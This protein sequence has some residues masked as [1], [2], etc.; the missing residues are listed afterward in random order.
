MFLMILSKLE[1]MLHILFDR[2]LDPIF[3]D[4]GSIFGGPNFDFCNTLH[5]FSRFFNISIMSPRYSQDPPKSLPRPLLGGVLGANFALLAR[6]WAL[7]GALGRS[8][9]A[10]GTLLG[11]PWTLLGALGGSWPLLR[12]SWDALERSW[13]PRGTLLARFRDLPGSILGSPQLLQEV[14]EQPKRRKFR[15]SAASCPGT[16]RD[17]SENQIQQRW[18]ASSLLYRS[19]RS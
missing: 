7:L 10:L 19:P 12:A 4:W 13:E 8:W 6:S 16:V 9:D 17:D 18:I 1:A 5:S 15:K 14:S 3:I 11:R 2:L